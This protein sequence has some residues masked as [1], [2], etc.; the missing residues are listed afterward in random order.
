MKREYNS[1][2]TWGFDVIATTEVTKAMIVN[3]CHDLS[4]RFNEIF[5]T[6]EY[7]FRPEPI[8]EGGIK[9]VAWP[10]KTERQYKTLRFHF[11]LDKWP[12][13]RGDVME[14]W[15]NNSDVIFRPRPKFAA[16]L[17]IKAF[18][19]APKWTLQE[20]KI[21]ADVLSSSCGMKRK[22]AFTKNIK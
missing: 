19:G 2:S 3:V 10:G 5:K 13:V 6:D 4:E 7:Q 16:E 17:Y 15:S 22:G 14:T 9:F 12:I 18:Y 11:N 8:T 1:T 20:L 21:F